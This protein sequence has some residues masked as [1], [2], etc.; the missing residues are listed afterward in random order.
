MARSYVGAKK[1]KCHLCREQLRYDEA[2]HLPTGFYHRADGQMFTSHIKSFHERCYIIWSTLVENLRGNG[3]FEAICHFPI[4]LLPLI[5]LQ[6]DS[7][8]SILV[9]QGFEKLVAQAERI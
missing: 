9:Q 6:D 5:K 8:K 1:V 7:V 3:R 4:E 2:L